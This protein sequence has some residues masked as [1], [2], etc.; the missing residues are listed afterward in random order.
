M[1][2]SA[3]CQSRMN[4][5]QRPHVFVILAI[6]IDLRILFLSISENNLPAWLMQPVKNYRKSMFNS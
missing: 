4:L 1:C 6:D 5:S 3:L 2:V